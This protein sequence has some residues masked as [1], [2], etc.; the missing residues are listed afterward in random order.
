MNVVNLSKVFEK[1]MV[2]SETH[3][4]R[5]KCHYEKDPSVYKLSNED[6]DQIFSD[7]NVF[8]FNLLIDGVNYHLIKSFT[9]NHGIKYTYE[10]P[11]GDKENAILLKLLFQGEEIPVYYKNAEFLYSLA[12]ALNLSELEELAKHYT[13]NGYHDPG[14]I[15]FFM[16]TF[17]QISCFIRQLSYIF[18][19]VLTLWDLLGPLVIIVF[20]YNVMILLGTT[21]INTINNFPITFALILIPCIIF[22]FYL[23]N[24]ITI[25]VVEFFKFNL[26]T[27][28][29]WST[30][31]KLF[32]KLLRHTKCG[33]NITKEYLYFPKLYDFLL[34]AL[35]IVFLCCFLSQGVTTKATIIL[36]YY[37][38][39]FAV[40][41]PPI[42]YALVLVM[43]SLHGLFSCFSFCRKRYRKIGDFSDPFLNAIYFRYLPYYSLKH[44]KSKSNESYQ[45]ESDQDDIEADQSVYEDSSSSGPDDYAYEEV[46][47]EGASKA[48]LILN[49][50]FSRN[51]FCLYI[52]FSVIAYIV[53]TYLHKT[54]NI[55]QLLT[56][57]IGL[58]VIT[59]PISCFMPLPFFWFH[60]IFNS[61]VPE[62]I[63]NYQLDEIH[64]TK[65]YRKYGRESVIWGKKH[66]LLRWA[67]LIASAVYVLMICLFVFL[68]VTV[69]GD[70]LQDGAVG[71]SRQSNLSIDGS[72]N[73]ELIPIPLFNVSNSKESKPSVCSATVKGMTAIQAIALAN[74]GYMYDDSRRWQLDLLLETYFGKNYNSSIRLVNIYKDPKHDCTLHHFRVRTSEAKLVVFSIRGTATLTDILVDIEWCLSQVTDIIT[75]I[76]PL[77][78]YF[79]EKPLKFLVKEMTIPRLVLGKNSLTNNY[80]ESLSNYIEA[81]KIL[82]DEDVLIVGHSL[83]GAIAKVIS[84]KHGYQVF[85]VSGP[86]VRLFENNIPSNRDIQYTWMSVMPTQDFISAFAIDDKTSVH[87]IPCNA[88][89]AKCHSNARTLCQ[90]GIICGHEAEFRDYC[91][92]LFTESRY[93]EMKNYILPINFTNS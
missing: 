25:C 57:I 87:K 41:L 92:L 54:A 22:T 1:K 40:L 60:R 72:N 56:I 13:K 18:K 58:Y 14:L 19:I 39:L 53:Y 74:T 10:C 49:A 46:Y 26:F 73:T 16:N 89:L 48:K 76:I 88:G 8:D 78:K 31:Q 11:D 38:L 75:P 23:V 44:L 6:Y 3:E 55:P 59:L 90:T 63:L 65:Q 67:S 80:I 17:K 83:G 51:T 91:K 35:F 4:S 93:Q 43:Y 33:K 85:S 29:P 84:M 45:S 24:I 82:P 30:I 15:S 36:E 27:R 52:F 47:E 2:E 64:E 77:F 69:T 61:V 7:K 12:K 34:G 50:I 86:N 5:C 37:L 28:T 32:M 79:G 66:M 9:S 20:C 42:K 68:V 21:S 81:Q 62:C 71:K 70:N